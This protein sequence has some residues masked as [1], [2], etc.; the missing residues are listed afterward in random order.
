MF[1]YLGMEGGGM[2]ESRMRPGSGERSRDPRHF[3]SW[4]RA[5]EQEGT[6]QGQCSD[7]VPSPHGSSE[8]GAAGEGGWSKGMCRERA[9]GVRLF[10]SA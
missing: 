7:P 10:S 9:R 5:T 3:L 8:Q 1:A 6:P 2:I 4:G